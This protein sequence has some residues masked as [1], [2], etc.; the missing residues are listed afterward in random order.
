MPK[1]EYNKEYETACDVTKLAAKPT[2]GKA[3]IEAFFTSKG[4]DLF[5]ILPR[6]PG[7]SFH[8][9]DVTG[10]KSVAPL[11]SPTPLKFKAVK[12]GV[13]I[14]LPALPEELMQQ[15]AWVLKVSQ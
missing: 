1:I 14:E 4:S 10:V 7:Q 5:A 9:K 13:S 11:G 15:P 2:P 12:G 6:W 3:G 8:V